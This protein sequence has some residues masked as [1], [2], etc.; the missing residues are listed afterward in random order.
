[1][2]DCACTI[3]QLNIISRACVIDNDTARAL[4]RGLER[5][6]HPWMMCTAFES[7]CN[8]MTIAGSCGPI[9]PS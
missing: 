5:R 7:R 6:T 3:S 1:M 9:S 4:K 2:H 8:E